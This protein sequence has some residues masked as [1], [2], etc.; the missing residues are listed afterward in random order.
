MSVR[1]E[2]I[3]GFILDMGRVGSKVQILEYGPPLIITDHRDCLLF[4]AQYMFVEYM[5]E[6]KFFYI[7]FIF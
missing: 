5:N 2:N 6:L 1:E 4:G 7:F 3:I